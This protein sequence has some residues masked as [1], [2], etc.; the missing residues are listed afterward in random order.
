[1]QST[2]QSNNQRKSHRAISTFVVGLVLVCLAL[3]VVLQR[4]L[5]VDYADYYTFKPTSEIEGIVKRAQLSDSGRF[6]F[7]ATQPRVE[8]SQKFN[9][10]CERKE[11]RTAVL[12]CYDNDRIY[13]Y[14]VTD[15]RLDGIKEVTA[16]HEMLHAVYQRM[17][18]DERERI[19]R[20]VEAEYEKL[21]NNP[22][23]AERMAFYARTEPGERDNELH[24]IIG[25]EVSNISPELEKHYNRYFSNRSKLLELFNSYN[26]LFVQ[27]DKQAKQ[28]AAELDR[29][30]AKLDSEI[31]SYNAKIKAL[32]EKI[33]D[34]NQRASDGGFSSVAAFN[35]ERRVLEQ[36]A[37]AIT[38][39]RASINQDAARYEKLRQ[40]YNDTITTSGDLYKS[41]DSTLA[42]APTV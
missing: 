23:F 26:N 20:L 5:I 3:F 4:Q 30:S 1:M 16:A 35:S 13:I 6:I 27:I 15:Q 19:D 32:N 22:D 41:I 9:A 34:F 17:S 42:P 10:S 11:E 2:S 37:D 12:G 28:L 14:N 25:T 24:S 39:Q 21:S 8:D 38:A 31:A 33:A 29:L 18:V 36:Q 7:Y 40:E